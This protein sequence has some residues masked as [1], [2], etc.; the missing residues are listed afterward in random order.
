[1]WKDRRDGYMD[2]K[3]NGDLQ[4]TSIRRWG[5]DIPRIRQTPGIRETKESMELT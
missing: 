3:M 5:R 1:V 4:L 2:I